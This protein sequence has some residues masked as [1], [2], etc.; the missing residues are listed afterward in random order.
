MLTTT[1]GKSLLA[2]PLCSSDFGAFKFIIF[3]KLKI[4]LKLSN[5]ESVEDIRS[6]V[7]T[8]MKRLTESGLQQRFQAWQNRSNASILNIA[9]VIKS[10]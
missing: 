8:L 9:A 7:I 4:S 2:H 3:P 1:F 10:Q 5:F 6:N